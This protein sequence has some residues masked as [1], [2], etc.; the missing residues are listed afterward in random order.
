MQTSNSPQSE[1]AAWLLVLENLVVMLGQRAT[2][3]LTEFALK[4]TILRSLY[5]LSKD[6]G[7]LSGYCSTVIYLS[8][9]TL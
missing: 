2:A 5:H 4:Q 8:V 6:P 1:A 7:K 3:E 9:F